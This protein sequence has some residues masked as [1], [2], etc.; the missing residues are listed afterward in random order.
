MADDFRKVIWCWLNKQAWNLL[1]WNHDDKPE[2]VGDT[3]Y[4][5]L[6]TISGDGPYY[7]ETKWILVNYYDTEVDFILTSS[8]ISVASLQTVGIENLHSCGY[9]LPM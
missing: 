5:S 7:H 4:S 1:W 9:I 8:V 2:L 6:S 3:L